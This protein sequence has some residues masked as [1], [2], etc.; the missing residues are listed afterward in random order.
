MTLIETK[1]VYL[2][3]TNTSNQYA[4]LIYFFLSNQYLRIRQLY[5]NVT[6]I[7][8]KKTYLSWLFLSN[9]KELFLII[10]YNSCG[11]DCYSKL[12]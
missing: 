4:L 1:I 7:I 3:N 2:K 8:Y 10:Y 6:F 11:F 9:L 5:H 12:T